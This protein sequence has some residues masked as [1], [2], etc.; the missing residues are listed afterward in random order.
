MAFECRAYF[1]SLNTQLVMSDC[2]SA[3]D[4]QKRFEVTR[5][6]DDFGA[7]FTI[8]NIVTGICMTAAGDGNQ[9]TL[10]IIY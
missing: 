10:P 9:C 2:N 3:N 6:I 8:T 4:N 1:D 7:S 5:A